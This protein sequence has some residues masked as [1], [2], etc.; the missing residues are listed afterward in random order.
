MD[1]QTIQFSNLT[2]E[3]EAKLMQFEKK[4]MQETG[5]SLYLIALDKK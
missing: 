4:F 2:P 1:D 3:Q 5:K